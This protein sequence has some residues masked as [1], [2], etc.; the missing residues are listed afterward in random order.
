M[1]NPGYLPA[2]ASREDYVGLLEGHA[3]PLADGSAYFEPGRTLVKSYMLETARNGRTLRDLPESFPKGVSLE[4][5]DDSL[6]RVHDAK[7][8]R[9][10][11]VGLLE[12]LNERHPVFIQRCRQR[13]AT[14]GYGIM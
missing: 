10:Q 8:H 14:D 13:T 6:F 2:L 9:G 1:E 4:V 3:A 5:V 12:R 7:E 11:V